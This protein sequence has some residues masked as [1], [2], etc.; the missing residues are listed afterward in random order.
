MLLD[1][2]SMADRNGQTALAVAEHFGFAGIIDDLKY[3]I[4]QAVTLPRRSPV[5]DC[6][7]EKLAKS[8]N[9]RVGIN[10]E[11]AKRIIH[12]YCLVKAR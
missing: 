9:K 5:P 1:L 10:I 4:H 3:T 6:E 12:R 7:H 2:G 8:S 11:A